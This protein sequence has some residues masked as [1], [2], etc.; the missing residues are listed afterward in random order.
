MRMD[1]MEIYMN[2]YILEM[3]NIDKSFPG[4]KALDHMTLRVKYGEAHALVGENGAGKSTLMKILSGAYAKDSGEIFIDGKEVEIISAKMAQ[5]LG[6]GIIYQEL[7][8]L[9]DLTVAENIFMGHHIMKNPAFVD[10]SSIYANAQEYLDRLNISIEAD[11]LVRDL[12]VG[13][14]QMVE[15]AK[16]LSVNA[17]ILIM[18]EPTAPLSN[19]ERD[20]L[21]DTIRSLKSQGITIIYISHRLEELLEIC[22]RATIIRDGKSITELELTGA[23]TDEIIHHMVGRELK[24]Q[25]PKIKVPI[26]DEVLRVEHLSSG[27]SVK[28]VSF[29]VRSG[30]ILGIS[31]LVG[32]GR[33]ETMRAL[34]GI[35]SKSSGNIYISGKKV[36]IS[37]PADAIRAGIGFVTEDRRNEG[38]VLMM[39]VGQN[40]TLASLLKFGSFLNI[41]L[42]KE[43]ATIEEYIERLKIKT[44]SQYQAVQNLSGG[45]QQ[46]AVLAKWM[47]S[48]AKIMIF[49]EP[50][51]GIDVGAKVEVYNIINELIKNGTAV[52]MISSELPEVMGMSD[53]IAVMCSGRI[54]G[55]FENDENLTQKK[56]LYYA[57][58]VG[59]GN[60]NAQQNQ[61]RG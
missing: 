44:P 16:A 59:N 33:T 38:L 19:H 25:Y 21:F 49:D 7:N 60:E 46:K 34:F 50:T 58:G 27:K 15:V 43:R 36:E 9:E 37:R 1:R 4:V 28:D 52:I 12:G 31:G 56:I 11:T 61:E 18:D 41:N 17:K 39:D 14:K 45:N 53:R 29:S 20:V 13:Q 51:R 23:T 26:G 30:E 57:V 40:I 10:W 55:V 35:D 32:A 2:H 48:D 8:L 6:I 22:E 42:N 54:N 47:L 5:Q 3:K 24:E